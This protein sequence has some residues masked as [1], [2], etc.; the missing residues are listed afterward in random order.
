[1]NR[2]K[3]K[4]FILKLRNPQIYS[5][6]EINVVKSKFGE[7]NVNIC[8]VFPDTYDIGMSHQGM[9]ILYHLLAGLEGVNVERAFLPEKGSLE[10]FKMEKI[11]LFSLES[12]TP[13]KYFDIIGFSILSEMS[14]TNILQ[15]L[16]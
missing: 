9:K 10:L 2:E 1:M 7:K 11:E 8:L 14:Y 6:K 12:K 15:V 16:D 4:K 5:G 13:L 3:T